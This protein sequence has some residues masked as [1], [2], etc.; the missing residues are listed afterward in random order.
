MNSLANHR[1]V[2]QYARIHR[3][4]EPR[5]AT[6]RSRPRHRA[7]VRSQRMGLGEILAGRG[8]VSLATIQ[9]AQEQQRRV[10]GRLGDILVEMGAL[11]T[12]QF[13]SEMASIE[14]VTPAAPRSLPDTGIAPGHLTNLMLKFMFVE[15]RSAPS[16]LARAMKLPYH[17]VQE[18]IADATH[19][20]LVQSL[21]MN[22]SGAFQEIHYTLSHEGRSMAADALRQNQYLGPAPVSLQSF[23][24]Q[25]RRQPITEERFVADDLLHAL[26]G[27]VVPGYYVRKV[28]PAMNAGQTILLFGPPG[29]GKTTLASRV[30]SL[31]RQVVYVPYAVEIAGQIMKVFDV[32]VHKPVLSDEQRSHLESPGLGADPFDDRWVAC[33]RPFAV[34]GGELTWEMLD[35]QYDAVSKFYDAPLHV[36]ALNGLFLIDDF[37]RQRIDPKALLN[38]WITPMENRMDYLRLHTGASFSLPFDELMIF[39]TNIDPQAIM[40]PALLRRISYK[41]KLYEPAVLNAIESRLR[42]YGLGKVS[43]ECH[44]LCWNMLQP[45]DEGFPRI[46]I[47][48]SLPACVCSMPCWLHC[49]AVWTSFPTSVVD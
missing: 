48:D 45:H 5:A 34:A 2:R 43:P 11:T 3:W 21:G 6:A 26:D 49:E 30:A 15:A 32:N 41:I 37:G 10:G 38:R 27:L 28:L 13:A 12:E 8:L 44:S 4:L 7:R 39:S 19:R 29:N 20:K 42:G 25:V 1:E 14:R 18:L 36:K 35:L 22:G 23:Q 24:H 40:D 31:F 17:L 9:A 33:R 47:S 46:G 16:D